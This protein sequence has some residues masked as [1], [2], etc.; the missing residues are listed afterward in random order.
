MTRFD[1]ECWK[2]KV[3]AVRNV[4]LHWTYKSIIYGL[5][6]NSARI[7]CVHYQRYIPR[8]AVIHL[9]EVQEATVQRRRIRAVRCN[10]LLAS[11][12]TAK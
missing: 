7:G 4:V 6:A 5:E 3:G 8:R 10:R 2:G 11:S 1:V 12:L 9:M